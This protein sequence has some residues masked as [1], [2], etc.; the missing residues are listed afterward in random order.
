[1]S[2]SEKVEALLRVLAH[3]QCG[4]EKG[5]IFVN[6]S[7]VNEQTKELQENK[8]MRQKEMESPASRGACTSSLLSPASPLAGSGNDPSPL[9]AFYSD[10]VV[11]KISCFSEEYQ[12]F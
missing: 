7:E 11:L 6:V 1:M 9:E 12:R 4:S 2:C 5:G 3:P 10:E 8:Q